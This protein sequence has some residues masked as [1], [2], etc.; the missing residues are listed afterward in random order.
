[1]RRILLTLTALCL[2]ACGTVGEAGGESALAGQ[3]IGAAV[4]IYGPW[5]TFAV[6]D[7]KPTYIWRRSYVAEEKTLFCEL[8]IELG[9]RRAISR[10]SMQGFPDACRLFGVRYKSKLR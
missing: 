5:E 1:M 2:A 3:D 9:F 6:L 10:S 7:G 4:G 8:R